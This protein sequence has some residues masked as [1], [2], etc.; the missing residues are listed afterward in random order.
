MVETILIIIIIILIC[1]IIFNNNQLKKIT[2]QLSNDNVISVSLNNHNIENLAVA[3]NHSQKNNKNEIIK[4]QQKDDKLKQSIADISHDLRTPLTAILGYIQLL[5]DCDEDSK[6]EYIEIIRKKS[7]QLNTL[8]NS[9]YDLSIVDDN[10]YILVNDYINIVEIISDSVVSNYTLIMQSKLNVI[11]NLPSNKMMIYANKDAIYRII[12]NLLSNSIKYAKSFID[13]QIIDDNDCILFCIKNDI[14][15]NSN[16]QVDK[17]FD[18]FYKSDVSR[19]T[20]STGIGLY[21]VKVLI[22]KINAKLVGAILID[23]VLSIT[24]AFKKNEF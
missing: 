8:I 16:I 3:I 15:D 11:N 7:E 4:V 10:D 6:N 9:F 14:F 21:I 5:N 18:R 13:V 23:D 19:S 20:Q 17:L 2:K 1:I 12:Q 22:E 24:I